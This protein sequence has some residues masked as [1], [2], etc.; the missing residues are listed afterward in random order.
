MTEG[1]IVVGAESEDGSLDLAGE[2]FTPAA[3]LDCLLRDG[4]PAVLETCRHQRQVISQTGMFLVSDEAGGLYEGCRCG[5]GLYFQD[6]RFLSGWRW[7]LEGTMPTLLSFSADRNFQAR[8]ELMNGHLVLPDGRQIPQESIYVS[9]N[10]LIQEV[11]H[12]RLEVV[13]FNPDAVTLRLSCTFSA[14]FS[15]MFEVRGA[16]RGERGR[17][18][19]P[20]IA[21][22]EAVLAYQGADGVFRSTRVRFSQVPQSLELPAGLRAPGFIATFDLSI[23]GRGGHACLETV[24]APRL[25]GQESPDLSATFQDRHHQLSEAQRERLA[26]HTHLSS[27]H[28][29]YDLV[30]RR[31]VLDLETLTSAQPLSGPLIAAGI[32]W[33]ACPF[34]RDALIAAYQT[35]LLGPELAQGTL[36]FL[37]RHQ[38][39]EVNDFRDEEPGKILHELRHGELTNLAQVPHAPYFGA[40]DSTPLFLILLSET[41]RW[42]GDLDFVRELWEPVEQA[43][44]WIDAYGDLDGDGFLEYATRSR[45]GLYNQNW[46]DSSNSNITPDFRIATLPIAVAEVQGYVYD[47]K[48][49]IAELCYALEL[50]VMGDRLVREAEELKQAFN[51]AFWLEADDFYALALDGAKRPVRTLTSNVAHGVWSG[52]IDEERL[53][54]MVRRLFSPDMFSGWGIRTMSSAMPPYNPLSYHNGSVWPHDNSLIAKGLAD[55]GFKREALCLMESLF[56][57]AQKFE[58]FRLPELFCGFPKQGDLDKPVPYPVA[59]A[60]QAWAAGASLLLLQA[61]LGLTPDAGRGQLLIRRPILPTWLQDVTL[62]GLRVGSTRLDLQFLQQHG[63][64]TTRVLRKEGGAMRI[65]IEG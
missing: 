38:G 21:G 64:T 53:P 52:I 22:E 41:Y 6:T 62:R 54:D 58:Y 42:T 33:F 35:L 60:P 44:M 63:V 16:F 24:I 10:R 20:K 12:E 55:H 19:K 13:N 59:C 57:A 61:V 18:F 28:E 45:L 56:D 3:D 2:S 7:Q 27:D 26:R 32:P 34:G 25:G 39:R 51:H 17:Y 31:S 23:P 40:I 43:L 8:I 50:R 30:L 11:V 49:R 65:L 14:D 48:R 29:I 1:A 15:D 46:K 4:M 47:A 36:R 9:V 37:A 5:T